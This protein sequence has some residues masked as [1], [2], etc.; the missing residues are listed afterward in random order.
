MKKKTTFWSK[1]GTA[2][3]KASD[4]AR[5]GMDKVGDFYEKRY[6]RQKKPMGSAKKT[7]KPFVIY[8]RFYDKNSSG[9]FVPAVRANR[10]QNRFEQW[11]MK[12]YSTLAAAKNAL[13]KQIASTKGSAYLGDKTIW[14]IRRGTT[15]VHQITKFKK[16]KMTGTPRKSPAKRKTMRK[17]PAKR[18]TK[19]C[20]RGMKKR[21]TSTRKKAKPKRTTSMYSERGGAL[22][23]KPF[24]GFM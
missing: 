7:S 19:A 8:F 14:Q 5:K 12:K 9:R 24:R 23:V 2:L 22:S 13:N 6:E 10:I 4:T 15:V 11:D 17:A 16:G 3:G 20:P 21:K 18:K 1:A